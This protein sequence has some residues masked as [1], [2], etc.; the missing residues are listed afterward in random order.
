MEWIVIVEMIKKPLPL[1]E[2]TF[3]ILLALRQPSHGYQVMSTVEA[4]SSGEVRIAAGTM[5][6]ALENLSQ[7]GFIM[8]V[9]SQDPRR[10]VYQITAYGQKRLEADIVRIKQMVQA[11]EAEGVIL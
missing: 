3:Y 6:G 9:P 1:T 10:K 4:M 2:T 7:N 5:Y 11:A 8:A